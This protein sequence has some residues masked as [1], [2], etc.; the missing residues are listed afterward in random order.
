VDPATLEKRSANWKLKAC[1]EHLAERRISCQ[2]WKS[3]HCKDSKLKGAPVCKE[4]GW[5][6]L[7]QILLSGKMPTECKVCQQVLQSQD[8]SMEDFKRDTDPS[9]TTLS[10]GRK[11]DRSLMRMRLV[12]HKQFKMTM[13]HATVRNPGTFSSGSGKTLI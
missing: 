1:R 9:T 8:F 4:G 11:A 12:T 2:A 13:V 6:K 10:S 7:L 5:N 3:M